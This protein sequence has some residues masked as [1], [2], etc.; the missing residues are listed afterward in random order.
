MKTRACIV[1]DENLQNEL[2]LHLLQ[3]ELGIKCKITHTKAVRKVIN[4]EK[5]KPALVLWDCS[6]ID[7][8]NPFLGLE[9][10]F[11]DKSNQH[12]TVLFNVT[13]SYGFEAEA[14][15]RGVRGIFY[16]DVSTDLF[17]KGIESI[18]LKGD[19]WYSRDSL[20]ECFVNNSLNTSESY[21]KNVHL[22]SR[23]NEV[24]AMLVSGMPNMKI[25]DELCI[26]NFTVKAHIH[27]IYKK[28][29]V[30]SR[31][32]AALWAAKNL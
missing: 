21:H 28:I 2:V 27:N 11:F 16:D 13:R 3:E 17:I 8:C 6:S 14:I 31:L 12:L 18:L 26:S 23:E 7:V 1:G 32:E 25:A 30:K 5:Q 20:I 29:N 15:R 24:L 9:I 22:T 19:L 10:Q 4:G